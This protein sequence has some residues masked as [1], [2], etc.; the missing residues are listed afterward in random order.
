MKS[1][2]IFLTETFL[3]TNSNHKLRNAKLNKSWNEYGRT[4]IDKK[5]INPEVMLR[6]SVYFAV[7]AFVVDLIN[8]YKKMSARELAIIPGVLR[9]WG[10]ELMAAII[11]T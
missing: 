7:P 8:R 2:P 3:S 5:M 9:N 11:F 10:D 6:K 1:N 4:N